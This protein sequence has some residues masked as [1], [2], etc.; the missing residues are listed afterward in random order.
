MIRILFLLLSVVLYAKTPFNSNEWGATGHRVVGEIAAQ[1][2]SKKTEKRI[3]NLLKGVSLA[4]ASNFADDIKSDQRYKNLDPWHYAN[5]ESN[6]NYNESLKNP[7]GDIVQAINTCIAV[8]RDSKQSKEEKIFHLKLLIHF[9]GDIH[10]PMHLGQPE[11]KGGND[12][13]IKWFGRNSNLHRLWDSD[14]IDSQQFSYSEMAMHLPVLSKSERYEIA[15]A[16]L[17]QW[18]NE[19][20]ALAQNIYATLPKDLDLG[21]KYRY[22]HF[23][24]IR[25]QLLKGGIRLAYVLDQVFK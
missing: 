17:S 19:S 8:L 24:T 14:I 10:Q 6:S 9:V 23:D 22:E 21:Y 16:P 3:N 5:V 25:L 11:D 1:Y 12:I 18:V 13:K 2:I 7:K 15:I 20:Y 4:Y